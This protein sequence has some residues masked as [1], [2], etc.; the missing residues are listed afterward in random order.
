MV[1]Q[2]K[3]ATGASDQ[4][5]RETIELPGVTLSQ[6]AVEHLK[7]VRYLTVYIWMAKPGFVDNVVITKAADSAMNF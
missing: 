6:Q 3:A 2:S 1:Y 5:K 4:W 7:K